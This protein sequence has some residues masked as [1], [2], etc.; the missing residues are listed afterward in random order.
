MSS[1]ID[2]QNS[3][4]R[5]IERNIN[6]IIKDTQSIK[7]DIAEIKLFI[8]EQEK[9]KEKAMVDITKGWWY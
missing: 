1:P 3:S 2:L 6:T 4:L 8:K 9:A 5:T 7:S